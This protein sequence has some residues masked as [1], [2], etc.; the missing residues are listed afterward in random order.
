MK[1]IHLLDSDSYINYAELQETTGGNGNKMLAH[2]H[3]VGQL[4]GMAADVK[5][6]EANSERTANVI[7]A[8]AKR[9]ASRSD[10]HRH[11]WPF[12]FQTSAIRQRGRRGGAHRADAS[13]INSQHIG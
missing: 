5:L 8:E 2:A 10:R 9:L 1:D 12:R 7:I 6:L 11:P 13:I 3:M 4:E